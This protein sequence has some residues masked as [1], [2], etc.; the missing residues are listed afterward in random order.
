MGSQRVFLGWDIPVPH[1]VARYL[2]PD[3]VPAGPFD[4]SGTLVITPTAQAGRRLRESLVRLSS[5]VDRA[6][7]GCCVMTPEFF[8]R[9]L[10]GTR[11]ATPLTE[12]A[13]WMETLLTV[14]LDEFRGLFPADPP[15]RTQAWA[16]STANMILRAR[17]ELVNDMKCVSDLVN[18]ADVK[19]VELERWGDIENLEQIVLS[20][21]REMGLE[22][23]CS[24]KCRAAKSPVLPPGINRI[25]LAAVP[26]PS[27]LAIHALN[28]LSTDV[29]VE[30][31]VHAPERF[32]DRFDAWGRPIP[33]CWTDIPVT[34]EEFSLQVAR[35]PSDQ[36]DR[37]VELLTGGMCHPDVSNVAIG[38]PD[39]EVTALLRNRLARHGIPAYDPAPQRFE[40]TSV[41][42]LLDGCMRLALTDEIDALKDL[43]HHPEILFW[44]HETHDQPGSESGRLLDENLLESLPT[45]LTDL[46]TRME[47]LVRAFRT[48]TSLFHDRKL[49][50]AIRNLLQIV[51]SSRQIDVSTV[52]GRQFA[53]IEEVV[54]DFLEELDDLYFLLPDIDLTAGCMLVR[55]RLSSMSVQVDRGDARI[56]LEGW[57]ELHWNDAP[58]CIVTG[59]NEGSVPYGRIEDAFLPDSFRSRLGLRDDGFLMARD[60]YLMRAMTESRTSGGR[61]VFITGRVG[62]RG[63]PLKPSRL[64]FQCPD[65]SLPKR[66]A[67]LFGEAVCGVAK[68]SRQVSRILAPS[69]SDLQSTQDSTTSSFRVTSLKDYLECPFRYYLKHE[70]KMDEKDYLKMEPD[71]LDF[72]NMV[73]HVFG[74]LMKDLPMRSCGD[75]AI[76]S[77]RLEELA[78]VRYHEVYGSHLS[79]PVRLS[80]DSAIRRLKIAASNQA[81]HIK[82]GWVTWKDP[83]IDFSMKTPTGTL[84]GRIDR[85]DR[86]D[87]GEILIVDYKTSDTDDKI[88]SRHAQRIKPN[89]PFVDFVIDC[90]PGFRWRDLQLPLYSF[91]ND[92]VS[93]NTSVKVAY[94]NVSHSRDQSMIDIWN[95]E[96]V[97]ANDHGIPFTSEL[98]QSACKCAEEIMRRIQDRRFWPPNKLPVNYLKRSAIEMILGGNPESVIDIDSFDRFMKRRDA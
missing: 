30:I 59:M 23:P 18:S 55:D 12:L 13:T 63:N 32:A 46:E 19:D 24:S 77:R 84:N 14:S 51:Y 57:L 62:L 50:V 79:F 16:I 8:S 21:L 82:S 91:W 75:E 35:S 22:D 41:F 31:L 28:T 89:D 87:A 88:S 90:H 10:F 47:P 27:G 83:E 53:L 86:N 96:R 11:I 71:P 36:A 52:H 43:M 40:L 68:P 60:S 65:E 5:D 94:F 38:V 98:R 72:G 4:F 34:D 93:E 67:R 70:L 33:G 9:P 42:R 29:T 58:L 81:K 80:L 95:S 15:F 39:A 61:M 44:L 25:V 1:S 3:P 76:I 69:V 48:L 56:D 6:V 37:V 54:S 45:S 64:L 66:A 20:K 92:G 26:D 7:I 17:T 85:I 73:H 74:E 2:L 49:N 78:R 97:A